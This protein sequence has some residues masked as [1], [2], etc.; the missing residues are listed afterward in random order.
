V[1]APIVIP[2]FILYTLLIFCAIAVG[3]LAFVWG[4]YRGKEVY[5]LVILGVVITAALRIALWAVALQGVGTTSLTFVIIDKLASLFFAL[6]ILVFV[7]V[8]GK[9]IAILMEASPL[10]VLILGLTA[11]A[12]AVAVTAVSIYYAVSIS[13]NYVSAFYGVYVADY[14]EIVLAA[15]TLALV[16]CLFVFTIIVGFRLRRY[17]S[18]ATSYSGGSNASTHSSRSNGQAELQA[19][20]EE[21]LKNLRIIVLGVGIMVLFLLFRFI[22]VSASLLFF[23]LT[24]RAGYVAQLCELFA[25]LRHLL[26]RRDNHPRG[27]VLPHHA[28]HGAIY[29]LSESPH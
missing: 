3:V 7:Y 25:R 21:K 5:L 29:V 23:V 12:V 9:A 26:R 22:L 6:T 2:G 14:A 20:V 4:S 1:A 11:V 10:V 27:R 18:G 17:S 13:R 28:G 15:F 24:K 8:W 16:I 19:S